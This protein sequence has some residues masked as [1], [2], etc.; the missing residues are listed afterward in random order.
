MKLSE[1]ADS[2]DLR[3]MKLAAREVP[4]AVLESNYNC[5]RQCIHCY[6]RFRD[7]VKPLDQIK[8]EIDLTMTKRNLETISI[9]GGEPTL[10]PHLPEIV[11][12]IKSRN[13][14][15]QILTNGVVLLKG[16][17]EALLDQLVDAGLDRVVLHVDD[18]QGLDDHEVE[19]MRRSLFAKFERRKICFALSITLSDAA[20]DAI[21]GVMKRYARYRY[22]DGILVTIARQA[23]QVARSLSAASASPELSDVYLNIAHGLQ[24][25]PASYLPS[26]LDDGEVRWLIYFY[27]LNA[28][29]GKSVSV[30][31]A[32]TRLMRRAYRLLTG[33]HLFALPMRPSLSKLWFLC[34]WLVEI[35]LVHV[36]NIR[37]VRVAQKS[38]WLRELRFQYIVVQSAPQFNMEKQCVEI[39]YHCPDATIRNGKLAPVCLADWM[40]PPGKHLAEQGGD[41][42]ISETVYAHLEEA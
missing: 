27:Y 34:T 22:F 25:E 18:G 1:I 26:S 40:S 39:C 23:D 17:G 37:Y 19:E 8:A 13:L 11:R 3:P 31:P 10:H 6:N 2:V 16:G 4:H 12:Y 32:F 29:T 42:R 33:R 24:V 5:N 21:P 14:V 28:A 36:Q 7:I 15:C 38:A 9:L 20:P 35:L 30:S 41:P